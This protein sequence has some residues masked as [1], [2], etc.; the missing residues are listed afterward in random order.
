[1]KENRAKFPQFF[2]NDLY[3]GSMQVAAGTIPDGY[4]WL[5]NM[6]GIKGT[7]REGMKNLEKF[8]S[9]FSPEPTIVRGQQMAI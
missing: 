2:P 4:K 7:I 3:L 1:M 8:G 6:L 9:F 5:S